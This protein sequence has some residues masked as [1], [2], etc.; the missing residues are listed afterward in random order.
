MTRLHLSP[1]RLA[2]WIA[3]LL[4]AAGTVAVGS[5]GGPGPRRVVAEFE[6][7]GLNVRPGD[8]VRVRGVPVG[9]IRSIQIVRRDFSARYELA[10]DRD[11]R[12]AADTHARLVP[13]TLFG[14]KYVELDGAPPGGRLL[15]DGAVIPLS[16]TRPAV[17][18]QQVLD[19]IR[20]VLG[21]VDPVAFSATLASLAEGLNGAE[22]D[23]QVIADGFPKMFDELAARDAQ[24][25]TLLDHVP[26]VAGTLEAR[27]DDLAS[28]AR[29][30]GHVARTLS[31]NE[32]ALATFLSQNAELSALAADLL[33]TEGPRIR[34]ILPDSL[35]VLGL[36][37]AQPGK[38]TQLTRGL[39]AFVGGLA[40]ATRTGAF[41]SPLAD[42]VL[43]NPGSLPDAK[44]KYSEGQGGSGVGP[45]VYVHG[46]E[47]VPN[48]TVNVGTSS[49][50]LAELLAGIS[51][52]TQ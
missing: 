1:S 14:D 31:T 7:A 6:R 15:A 40:A 49:S 41:R 5:R 8:E 30:F 21:E 47:G 4:V 48:P 44:G 36:V 43:L 13:K 32:P 27:S 35:D 51:G 52:G 12:I 26:G 50:G 22:G 24:L 23:L 17:E 20:P 33:I 10:I 11:A 25:G 46:L 3:V 34:R 39:P 2:G 38:I 29:N 18:V 37:A 45:D 16:R 9:T 28:A 19:K 42:F